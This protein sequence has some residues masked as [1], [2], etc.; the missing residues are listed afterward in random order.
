MS[1][2][3]DPIVDPRVAVKVLSDDDIRRI[4]DATLRVI[5]TVGV[6]FPSERA[7]D[8]WEAHGA[9]VDRGSTDPWWQVDLGADF[10]VSG[11]EIWNRTD[12]CAERLDKVRIFN[13]LLATAWFGFVGYRLY[14]LGRQ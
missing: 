8:L 1:G 10:V 11:V 12:C 14:R 9:T 5:E 6:R 7:L 13:A 3:I 2:R 4:H